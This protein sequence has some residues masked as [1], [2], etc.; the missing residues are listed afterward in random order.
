MDLPWNP[1][2]SAPSMNPLGQVPI[3]IPDDH[4]P[5]YESKV[6][7][8][9]LETLNHEPPLIPNEPAAR[10]RAKQIEA[11]TDGISDAVVLFVLETFRASDLQ[12]A[13]WIARQKS[14]VE[15]GL[16]GLAEF[17]GDQSHFVGS[18]LSIADVNAGCAL[19]YISFRWPEF[20]WR[21]LYPNLATFSDAMEARFSFKATRPEPQEIA[22][23]T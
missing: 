19:G 2:A 5:V 3:L 11:L 13:D 15:R 16:E 10:V 18:A 4:P 23:V 14:K 1:E 9:Y 20:R 6:I 22:P 12:S 17:L 8:E 7:I 21:D